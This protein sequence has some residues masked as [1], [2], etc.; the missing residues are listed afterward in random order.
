MRTPEGG[1][2]GSPTW[3]LLLPVAW[4]LSRSVT[5]TALLSATDELWHR[6]V[7]LNR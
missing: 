5:G 2:V 4:P 6:S 7:S 1:S 3:R